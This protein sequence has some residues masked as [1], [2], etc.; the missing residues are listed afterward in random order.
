M[1]FDFLKRKARKVT[2]ALGGGSARGLAH[3]GV[4]KE[5]EKAAIPIDMVV[6]TSMG[7]LIGAAYCTGSDPDSMR[8]HA[9]KFTVNRLLDPTIPTMGLL[10]GERLERIIRAMLGGKTFEDC[11]IPFAAVTTDMET[12]Q[13]VVHRSGDMV[14]AVRASCSWAGIF[15]PV[16]IGG[17]LLCDG[18]I[19]SSVPTKVARSLGADYLIAVDVGFCVKQGKMENIFQMILQSFQ[20][21]GEELNKYQSENSDCT[22]KVDLG[23]FD[24]VAFDRA[25]EA[26]MTGAAA[27]IAKIPSI[28]E[29][30]GIKEKA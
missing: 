23:D 4:I 9:L 5:L 11:R 15:N 27:A 7:A 2:L 10:A 28:K 12:G 21:M 6:G 22:I 18:G 3:I 26:I 14:K 8:Y 30:L 24:Q 20:I 19:K 13:E 29:D 25:E 16:T 17:K 1:I